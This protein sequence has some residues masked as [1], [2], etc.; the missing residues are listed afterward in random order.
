MSGSNA[1]NPEGS[2]GN[3]IEENEVHGNGRAGIDVRDG[4]TGN[5]IVEN[6]AGGNAF[7]P[8]GTFDLHD[9][10]VLDNTWD[11][12]EGTPNF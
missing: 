7:L 5:V 6:D 11:D 9:E 1:N 2:D 4:S 8:N 10:G 3:L 12:N